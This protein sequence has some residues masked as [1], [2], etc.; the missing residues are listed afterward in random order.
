MH[1]FCFEAISCMAYLRLTKLSTGKQNVLQEKKN[2]K[3]PDHHVSILAAAEDA[4]CL[5]SSICAKL[6]TECLSYPR[7]GDRRVSNAAITACPTASSCQPCRPHYR[8]AVWRVPQLVLPH[9]KH[10]EEPDLFYISILYSLIILLQILLSQLVLWCTLL[11][12]QVLL[13]VF[14]SFSILV[15]TLNKFFVGT[16]TIPF[17]TVTVYSLYT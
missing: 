12:V 5:S 3:L 15:L 10:E 14:N 9:W 11:I 1:F 6:A 8:H 7:V 13:I 4:G 16:L 2:H 17:I